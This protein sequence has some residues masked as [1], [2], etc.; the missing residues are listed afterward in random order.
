MG[1]S[2]AS[3]EDE[4]EED[5]EEEEDDEEE[6]ASTCGQDAESQDEWGFKGFRANRPLLPPRIMIRAPTS[7]SAGRHE[8][9]HEL[10]NDD[11]TGSMAVEPSSEDEDEDDK[12]LTDVP[13]AIAPR[14]TSSP[15]AM[16]PPSLPEGS[17]A[18]MAKAM[19]Y[20]TLNNFESSAGSYQDQG[21]PASQAARGGLSLSLSNDIVRL[22][23]ND[24]D[25]DNSMGKFVALADVAHG[26]GPDW[27]RRGSVAGSASSSSSAFG[28]RVDQ[29]RD[30]D[31]SVATSLFVEVWIIHI[32]LIICIES[33]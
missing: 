18:R 7:Y 24:N 30:S 9:E 23:A 1:G 2:D 8:H 28:R 14:P 16:R 11:Y 20:H 10:D 25:N 13:F 32:F 22:G 15:L 3:C 4:A 33:N 27:L 5:S 17:R 21:A 26:S 19:T 29:D 6:L 31:E 12:Q